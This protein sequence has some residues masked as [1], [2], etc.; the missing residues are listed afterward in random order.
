MGVG[1]TDMMIRVRTHADHGRVS[2][3]VNITGL[4]L[5][6]N[7]PPVRR[8]IVGIEVESGSC[9]SQRRRRETTHRII[10]THIQMNCVKA[11]FLAHHHDQ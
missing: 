1:A 4:S 6:F 10:V 5:C 7:H 2:S 8:L 9:Q 3:P 11:C